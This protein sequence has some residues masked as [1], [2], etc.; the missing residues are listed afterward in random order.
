MIDIEN[1]VF[2]SIA[3]VL[4]TEFS[5]ISV[6]GEYIDVPSSFPCVTIVEDDN[7]TYQRSQDT[8]NTEHHAN[9]VYTV[10]VYSNLTNG[11]KDQA[12][13]IMDRI[14]SLMQGMKFTRSMRNQIPNTDRTIYRI[15]ARYNA[16]VEEAHEIDGNAVYQIYRS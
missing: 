10:N 2:N 7:Y 14:D 1:K 13:K 5:G 12:K 15:T 3:S 11:K 6:Y 9:I 16:V 8:S 4:R